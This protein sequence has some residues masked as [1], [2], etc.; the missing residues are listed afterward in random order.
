MKLTIEHQEFY[1]RSELL[2]RSIFGFLYI[3]LPH[4]FLLFFY[5]LWGNILGFIAWW[6]I[7]FTG[8]YPE[9]FFAYQVN[10]MRWHLRLNARMWNLVDEY[11]AFGMDAEDSKTSLEIPNPPTLSR[12]MLLVKSFFGLIYCGVPHAVAL[13]GRMIVGFVLMTLGWWVILFTGK[14]PASW[15]AYHTGTLRWMV[16]V[17]LYLSS[18]SDQYPPFSG[19][20]DEELAA[21]R[22]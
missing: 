10:L 13:Y 8:R 4:Q 11:P 18:M 12:G 19:K 9:N 3:G 21:V 20:S 6:I 2:I 17:Q 5:G 16:R 22:T 7:L 15:H 14:L 1:S